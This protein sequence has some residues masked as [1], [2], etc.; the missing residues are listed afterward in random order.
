MRGSPSA[1]LV[2][3]ELTNSHVCNSMLQNIAQGLQIAR[4]L[5]NSFREGI[6]A[7]FCDHG[8]ETRSSIQRRESRPNHFPTKTT[9]RIVYIHFIHYNMFRPVLPVVLQLHKSK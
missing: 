2:D 8:D 1:W 5:G 3:A 4:T 6:M 7:G 9:L